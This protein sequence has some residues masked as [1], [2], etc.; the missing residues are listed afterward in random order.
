MSVSVITNRNEHGGDNRFR[1]RTGITERADHK[2]ENKKDARGGNG[3]RDGARIAW[4]RELNPPS[5]SIEGVQSPPSP[6]L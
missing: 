4:V 6:C 3:H 5:P 2:I 1:E